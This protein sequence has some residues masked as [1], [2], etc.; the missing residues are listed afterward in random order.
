MLLLV[1]VVV[2]VGGF[3]LAPVLAVALL[4]HADADAAT[5]VGC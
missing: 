2:V 3:V 4:C 1:S 5:L